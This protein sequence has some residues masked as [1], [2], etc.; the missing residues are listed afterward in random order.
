MAPS[1][2]API[3]RS[4]NGNHEFT[5]KIVSRL[6]KLIA[7]SSVV[8]PVRLGANSAARRPMDGGRAR[9]SRARPDRLERGGFAQ[10]Y[11]REW[12][13]QERREAADDEHGLPAERREHAGGHETGG[14]IPDHHARNHRDDKS[15]LPVRWTDVG[16]QRDAHRDAAAETDTGGQARERELGGIRDER[17]EQRRGAESRDAAEEHG[18]AAV[19]VAEPAADDRT[20]EHAEVARRQRRRERNR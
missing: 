8:G 6:R 18:L 4:I 10:E 16:H 5:K 1:G 9:L 20:G 13:Q 17:R 2:V 3:V 11:R 12:Q 15:A 14:E 7:Q 19:A